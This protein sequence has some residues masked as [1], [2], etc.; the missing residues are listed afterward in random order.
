MNRQ[1]A[2]L[3][4]VRTAR[5]LTA[6]TPVQRFPVTSWVYRRVFRFGFKEGEAQA[7]FRGLSLTVP[8]RDVTIVPGILGGW[9][10]ALVLDAFD[11][12]VTTAC[13]VV[14]VGGNIGLYTC[15]AAKLLPSEGRVIVF[16]P[17]LENLDLLRRNVEANAH[18]AQVDV[19]PVAVGD[20]PGQVL[21][22]LNPVNVGTHSVSAANAHARGSSVRVPTVTLDDACADV[23]PVDVLKIDVEGYDGHVL[24]GALDVLE[25]RPALF[26]EYVP[27]HLLG[28]GFPPEEFLDLVFDRYAHV[29]RV[30]DVK[31]TVRRC[32]RDEL[33]AGAAGDNLN[34]VAVDRADHLA[35]LVDWAPGPS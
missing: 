35:A 11:A 27:A 6:N 22:H 30:D 23:R 21:L 31:Q 29:F 18:V 5:R 10:E 20:R 17:V 14:D 2:T 16:E 12:L 32:E 28:C 7:D 25:D 13:N 24:R 34:L 4:V 19:H 8:T 1:R 33:V 15:A 9:Y 26:V 3:A